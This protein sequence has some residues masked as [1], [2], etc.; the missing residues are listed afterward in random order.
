[1]V[2]FC[3]VNFHK[4]TK[5]A[6]ECIVEL[7]KHA[8]IFKNTREVHREARGAGRTITETNLG[9]REMNLKFREIVQTQEKFHHQFHFN[10]Y[11]LNLTTVSPM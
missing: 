9:T 6:S 3:W 5:N 2:K 11:I 8:G 10:Q 1:M 4:E 7:Y